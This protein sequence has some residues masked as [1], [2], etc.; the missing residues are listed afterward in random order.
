MGGGLAGGQGRGWFW[1]MGKERGGVG[2]GGGLATR[3]GGLARGRGR[4]GGGRHNVCLHPRG[5]LNFLR[6]AAEPEHVPLFGRGRGGKVRVHLLDA[7]KG[8]GGYAN[9]RSEQA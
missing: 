5:G 8:V 3:A 7:D 4:G 9:E 2:G 1:F 6:L